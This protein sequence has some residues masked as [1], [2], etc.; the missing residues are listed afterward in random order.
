MNRELLQQYCLQKKGVTLEFPFEPE[1]MV[2]KV[3]GKMFALLYTYDPLTIVLKC[4]PA[5]AGVLRETYP[6][7]QPGWYKEHWNSVLVDG[8]IPADEIL[9][10]I[11]HSY[12]QVVKRLKKADREKLNNSQSPL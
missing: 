5:W 6:A 7:V 1:I 4:D 8:S 10:I 9:E 12:T 3:L 11:D 2:F